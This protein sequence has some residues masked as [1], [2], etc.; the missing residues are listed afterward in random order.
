MRGLCPHRRM[1]AYGVQHDRRILRKRS[2]PEPQDPIAR[3]T[4]PFVSNGVPRFVQVMHAAIQ[5]DDQ[6]DLMT[7]E[8]GD[9]ACDRRLPSELQSIQLSVPQHRP[10]N[11]LGAGHVGAEAA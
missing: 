6:F 1:L 11:R 5:F 4:K 7:G 9:R 8:V 2:I 3:D 10:Q